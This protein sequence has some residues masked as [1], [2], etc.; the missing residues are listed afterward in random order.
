MAKQTIFNVSPYYDDYDEDKNFLRM[1][2]RPGYAVQARELTQAQTILQNQIERFGS[3]V[4]EEGARVLGAGITTRPISFIRV[5]PSYVGD[6]GVLANADLTKLIG[7]DLTG[8]GSDGIT[9][10][11]KVV[12]GI[13]TDSNGLDN[14][15]ILFIEFLEGSEFPEGAVLDSSFPSELHKVQTGTAEYVGMEISGEANLVSLDEG[16]FYVDGY[17]VKSLKNSISPYGYTG[18]GSNKRDFKNPTSRVGFSVVKTNVSPTEDTTLLDPASG[19]YNFNAPG[20]DRYRIGLDMQFKS[21]LTG[22]EENFIELLKYEDGDV[23]YKLIKTNYAELEKTLARRTYDESGSYTVKPFDIDMREHL[24]QGSNRGIYSSAAGGS[25]EQLAVGMLTG[26]SY[27][28]GHEYETQ[29]TEYL[30]VN[31]ARK[32]A[33]YTGFTLDAHHGNYFICTGDDGD[34]NYNNAAYWLMSRGDINKTPMPIKIDGGQQAFATAKIHK[35]G[36]VDSGE[37]QGNFKVYIYDL[38]FEDGI[39]SLSGATRVLIDDTATQSS[40]SEG[41]PLDPLT[42][43]QTKLFRIVESVVGDPSTLER[44][45][46]SLLIPVGVGNAVKEVN[47]FNYSFKKTFMLEVTAGTEADG[48]KVDLGISDSTD[49]KA[50]YNFKNVPGGQNDVSDDFILFKQTGGEVSDPPQI[51]GE[52]TNFGSTTIYPS[53]TIQSNGTKQINI[54]GLDVTGV[55]KYILQATVEYDDTQS[56]SIHTGTGIRTKSLIDNIDETP[57]RVETNDGRVYY[58]LTNADGFEI[59][60]VTG[61]STSESSGGQPAGTLFSSNNDFIFD[62]GQRDNEYLKSRLWVKEGKTAAYPMITNDDGTTSDTSVSVSYSHFRHDGGPGPFTVDSY[63]Y[64]GFTYDNIP[65]YTSKNLKKTYSLANVLDFRHTKPFVPV[66]I[67]D[68]G[69][70][71]LSGSVNPINPIRVPVARGISFGSRDIQE[72]HTYYLSRIDKIALKN[73]LNGDVSFEVIEGKDALVPKAPEDK[74]NAMTLYSLSIPAY[75]HNPDDVR[76]KYI[77]NKR[78]TMKDLGKVENRVTDLEY[79]TTISLLENEIDARQIPS[80]GLTSDSAFK[81]GILVDTFKGH[82]VGDVSHIDYACSVDYEKGQLRPSFVPNNIALKQS[83]I[84]SGLQESS[85]GIITFAVGSTAEV[86]SQPSTSTTVTVNPFNVANWLGTVE[87]NPPTINWYDTSIRPKVKINSQGENDNW[88]VSSVNNLRG[89]GTQWNDWNSGW[90]GIDLIQDEDL[91]DRK[92]KQFLGQARVQDTGVPVVFNKNENNVSSV[93]RDAS[94]TRE[95]KNRS[96]LSSRIIPEHIRKEVNGKVVDLSV[97]PFIATQ[98]VTMNGYGMKPLTQVNCFFDDVNVDADCSRTGGVVGPFTTD[99][100][101]NLLEVTFTIPA[102]TFET[103]EKKFRFVNDSDNKLT[104]ATTCADG[105]LYAEGISERRANE[106]IS[107]R[108]V[109]KRRQTVKSEQVI[110]NPYMRRKSFD[111]SKYTNWIDPLSQIFYVDEIKYPNGIF[112]DSVDLYLAKVDSE[113]PVKVDIRPTVN[114]VPSPS[115]IVPFSEVWKSDCVADESSAS[116]ATPFAFSTPVYLEPG[117]YA[118]CVSAN[119][120]NYKLHA[121]KLGDDAI[122]GLEGIGFP[123]YTGALFNATNSREAEPDSTLNL[124]YKLYKSTFNTGSASTIVEFENDGG[125]GVIVDEYQ[126]NSSVGIPLGT[127][128]TYAAGSFD[129]SDSIRAGKTESLDSGSWTINSTEDVATNQGPAKV[130]VTLSSDNT[131]NTDTTPMLDTK[132]LNLVCVENK[133]NDEFVGATENSNDE[134]NAYGT[135]RSGVAKYITRRVTLQDDFEAKNIKVLLDLNQQDDTRIEVY[136]KYTSKVDETDFDD[137]GYTRMTVENSSD[138]FVSENEFDFR[139][140]SYTLFTTASTAPSDT[141]R[142]KSFAIKVCMFRE[143][144]V[145]FVPKIK[146]LRIVALDS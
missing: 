141:D 72:N 112:L 61:G 70:S 124:K 118:I 93:T 9:A 140:T 100:N 3:H 40:N 99:I 52:T 101:G 111:V 58:E 106:I 13:G 45:K 64:S 21:G 117:E 8:T 134:E 16:V 91:T 105:I 42:N 20:A 133:I 136:A 137:V 36:I 142:I 143:D 4:F 41:T 28:F 34:N 32:T 129:G 84:G 63:T 144:G 135:A 54:D 109:H 97:S 98:G 94:T 38:K 74:E 26:K 110:N 120:A 43:E 145:S 79:Y 49:G 47:K 89:F 60:G 85:D 90:Y 87:I 88:K 22:A 131:T 37:F 35:L 69:H 96:G 146:D 104:N 33:Q 86:I 2:F 123:L 125:L 55:T 44:D 12:H 83:S 11:A 51:P 62:N 1:L 95:E 15:N 57:R 114:G 7:Y 27:V 126:L 67:L 113:I 119:S 39:T 77:E 53:A 103:G 122:D 81:N 17:F 73:S 46:N 65:L 19:S 24:V 128:I 78:Y 6:S 108:P 25:A 130:S 68:F 71:G 5:D 75:T 50:T 48:Y 102:N 30:T 92:G 138:E 132:Y 56:T 18:P 116:I 10:R 59:H 139:E 14:S 76:I 31:K 80:V 127:G 66:N 82:N 115:T 121:A 29:S 107:T 23:T